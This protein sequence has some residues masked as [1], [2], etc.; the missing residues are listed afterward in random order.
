MNVHPRGIL[1]ANA[2]FIQSQTGGA[3]NNKQVIIF[4]KVLASRNN[5]SKNG[6]QR[7]SCITTI[8]TGFRK[9]ELSETA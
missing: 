2:H 1:F 9:I 3:T 4:F 8:E 5:F 7:H 6:Y